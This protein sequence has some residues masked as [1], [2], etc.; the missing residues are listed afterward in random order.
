MLQAGLSS[1]E[2]TKEQHA[3]GGDWLRE[4]VF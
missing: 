2:Q 3:H 1:D 4:T